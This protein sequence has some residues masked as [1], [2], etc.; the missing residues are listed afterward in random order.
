MVV[1][2]DLK[3]DRY[4][5]FYAQSAG[6]GHNII[7]MVNQCNMYRYQKYNYDSLFD[8]DDGDDDD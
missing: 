3:T 2:V 4:W 1:L 6:K 5:R 7:I 8:D